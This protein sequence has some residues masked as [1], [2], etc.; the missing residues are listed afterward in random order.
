MNIKLNYDDR[1]RIESIIANFSESDNEHIYSL[2]EHDDR[3]MKSNPLTNAMRSLCGNSQAFELASD[4]TEWLEEA[5]KVWWDLTTKRYQ[6][7]Y[8]LELYIKK[9][10]APEAA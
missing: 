8:A 1:K 4:T 2:V 10:E 7:E 3:Q 5:H 6:F 9:L